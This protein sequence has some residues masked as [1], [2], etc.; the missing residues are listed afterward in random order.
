MSALLFVGPTLR[1][2]ELPRVPGLLALPPAAQGDLYRA[3][4]RRPRAIGIIDGYFDGVPSVWHKEILWAMAQGIHVMGSASR[5]ALRA[6]ELHDFGMRGVGR[7]YEAYRDGALPPY[8]GRFEDDDEVAVIHGPAETGYLALSE[9][10]VN[11]RATLAQASLEGLIEAATRDALADLAKALFYHDRSYDRLLA[12]AARA[13][14]PAAQLAALGAWLPA[15]RVDQKRLDANAMLDAMAALLAGE[16]TPLQVGY[17]LEWTEMWDDATLAAAGASSDAAW[18]PAQ[19]ILEELRL[20]P[21]YAVARDRTLLRFLAGREAVRRRAPAASA[22]RRAELD[23]LRARHG[24]FRRADLDR[25]LGSSDLDARRLE[26][27]V[28]DEAH[29]RDVAAQA[30][31]GLDDRLL[32]DLRLHGDYAG[33]ARRAGDKQA[34]LAAQGLDQPRAEDVGVAPPT[35]LAWYFERRLNLPL[36]DD[37][38]GAARERGFTDRDQFY[39]ALLR[40]WLY[41]RE[42]DRN[43]PS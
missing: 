24:L 5:G 42:I 9:A 40:E 43:R 20:D 8:P 23:R 18:L 6:A 7:I 16:A 2:D 1:P 34:L 4:Q 39:R 36:P 32:D 13:A 38:D 11:I 15:G 37:I 21:A 30:A 14:L 22:S 27:L 28:A 29:L 31:A 3:A 12:L 41:C 17:T 35:L 10:M 25:W 26:Q 19:R 33:L